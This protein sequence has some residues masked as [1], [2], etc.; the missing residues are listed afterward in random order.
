MKLSR[1]LAAV[2]LVGLLAG[3]VTGCGGKKRPPEVATAPT[4]TAGARG[5]STYEP[6]TPLEP[7]PDVRPVDAEGL[8]ASDIVLGRTGA[9]GG[10]LADIRFAFDEATLSD[11]ARATLER[12]ALWLQTHRDVRVMVE[13][14]CDERGTVEYNLALGDQRA[15]AAYDYLVGLGVAPER[16]TTVSYGKERPLDLGHDEASWA[17][18]RRAAF[19]VSR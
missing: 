8:G 16:L 9:E 1:P 12:H 2:A 6:A 19:V 4:G 5:P 10:P 14:H 17:R 15:R 3:L 13:G 18:N 7:G 11:E